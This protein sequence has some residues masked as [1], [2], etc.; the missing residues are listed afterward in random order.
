[1]LCAIWRAVAESC[2]FR[3]LNFLGYISFPE[4]TYFA[5]AGSLFSKKRLKNPNMREV[6]WNVIE[7]PRHFEQDDTPLGIGQDAA[8][9]KHP[10]KIKRTSKSHSRAF[11]PTSM[12]TRKFLVIFIYPLRTDPN[13]HSKSPSY[14]WLKFIK[15]WAGI[16]YG[17]RRQIIHHF[18][19][20][21][22]HPTR[23]GKWPMIQQG[24]P[25]Q[26]QP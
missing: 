8:L 21:S 20:S 3:G 2:E 14:E 7:C 16:T 26:L 10:Q 9:P 15:N 22:S 25:H 18:S 5:L 17:R 6:F 11:S 1:M 23:L 4:L 12:Q 19:P 13:R 24:S